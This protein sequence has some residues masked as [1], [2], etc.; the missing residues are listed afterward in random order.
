MS[1]GSSTASLQA[2]KATYLPR[3]QHAKVAS[4][5]VTVTV[6]L[7]FGA[8]TLAWWWLFGVADL[9]CGLGISLSSPV[10]S[11]EPVCPA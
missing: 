4:A 11:L 8:V 1:D 10:P 7:V 2:E 5:V 6:L 9:A 3:E